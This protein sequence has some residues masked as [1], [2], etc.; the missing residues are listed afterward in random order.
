MPGLDENGFGS[1]PGTKAAKDEP[2]EPGEI[3]TSSAEASKVKGQLE[4]NK[5]DMR[6]SFVRSLPLKTKSGVAEENL[7][8]DYQ[9]RAEEVM[10]KEDIP[11]N[12]REYI[13]NYFL[14]I[15]VIE[16]KQ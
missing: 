3:E 4:L 12:F 6:R 15:G 1:Q 11:L 16:S 9:R 13:R 2:G 7:L 10:V 14:L 5:G 8:V